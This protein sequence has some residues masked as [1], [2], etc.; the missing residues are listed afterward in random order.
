LVPKVIRWAT[1]VHLVQSTGVTKKIA[2]DLAGN[3]KI[4]NELKRLAKWAAYDVKAEKNSCHQQDFMSCFEQMLSSPSTQQKLKANEKGGKARKAPDH[5]ARKPGTY[6]PE[7]ASVELKDELL[8]RAQEISDNSPKDQA[9][10]KF[11]SVEPVLQ[12]DHRKR[13]KNRLRQRAKNAMVAVATFRSER[14]EKEAGVMAR[15]IFRVVEAVWIL[16]QVWDRAI[17]Y[18]ASPEPGTKFFVMAR[19]RPVYFLTAWKGNRGELSVRNLKSEPTWC[20]ALMW[21]DPETSQSWNGLD[22]NWPE[23]HKVLHGDGSRMIKELK[24]LLVDPRYAFNEVNPLPKDDF[25]WVEFTE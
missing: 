12:Q 6:V 15:T 20:E 25:I 23:W 16:R 2:R 3:Y 9:F 1:E 24:E 19:E 7:S 17:F 21:Q 5:I 11:Q 22:E 18:G 10:V 13:Y 8:A 14:A 4:S